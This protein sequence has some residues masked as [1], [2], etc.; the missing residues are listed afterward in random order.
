M[1]N[2]IH[3]ICKM[4]GK[5][6]GDHSFSEIATCLS[7]RSTDYTPSEREEDLEHALRRIAGEELCRSCNAASIA[8]DALSKAARKR[9]D[10]LGEKQ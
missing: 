9:S 3:A 4:C 6:V 2:D 8:E 7:G 1:S 10:G 5:R